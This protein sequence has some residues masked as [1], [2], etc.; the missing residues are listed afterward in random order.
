MA[1]EHVGVGEAARTLGVSKRAV[2][3][4]VADGKLGVKREGATA[5]LVVSMAPVEKALSWQRTPGTSPGGRAAFFYQ[6][7]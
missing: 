6:A 3:N 4:M 1:S 2:R 7:G 5:R